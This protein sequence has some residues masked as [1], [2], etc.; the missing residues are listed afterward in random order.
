ME[1][2]GLDW[3]PS[4]QKQ[5][6]RLGPV[7]HLGHDP[8]KHWQ[9]SWF[10]QRPW[11]S[12]LNKVANGSPS[13]GWSAMERRG[14]QGR[15]GDSRSFHLPQ[16]LVLG[17]CVS[18]LVVHWCLFSEC[19]TYGCLWQSHFSSCP[20]LPGCWKANPSDCSDLHYFF[21]PSKRLNVLILWEA[22]VFL[23]WRISFIFNI[24]F[25]LY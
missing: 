6:L 13:H 22:K 24:Y 9:S 3:V 10:I 19:Q 7:V 1:D 12:P 21:P 8:R 18:P 14:V 17:S 4:P 15:G 5:T 20:D 11:G 25:S 16:F 2:H 23:Y